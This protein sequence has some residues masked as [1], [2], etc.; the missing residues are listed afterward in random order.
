MP[1]VVNYSEDQSF[2]NFYLSHLAVVHS[3]SGICF[4]GPDG[5][6]YPKST[7]EVGNRC[8]YNLERIEAGR[9]A[10]VVMQP[11][12]ISATYLKY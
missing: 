10:Q 2:V 4:N 7:M 8:L 3:Y 6:V 12:R 9:L 11:F 5:N 1:G